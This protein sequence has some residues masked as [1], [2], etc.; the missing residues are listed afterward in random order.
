MVRDGKEEE[1]RFLKTLENTDFLGLCAPL[2]DYKKFSV[3]F[4]YPGGRGFKSLSR[5]QQKESQNHCFR[6][7]CDSFFTFLRSL[8]KHLS[9]FDT[10]D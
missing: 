10:N 5:N 1:S 4:S 9:T 8:Q 3:R 7:F 2:W 6:W